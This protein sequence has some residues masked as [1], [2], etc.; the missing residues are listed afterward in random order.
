MNRQDRGQRAAVRPAA[1]LHTA[2]PA[3]RGAVTPHP[4]G[5]AR[6]G[7]SAQQIKLIAVAAMVGDHLAW[8]LLSAG[9]GAGTLLHLMGRI[10]APVM[11]FFVAE[12][13][14]HSSH[15]GRYLLR[16]LLCAVPS[17]FAYVYYF[18]QG[19]WETTSVI[20]GLFCGLAALSVW[21]LC[22]GRRGDGSPISVLPALLLTAGA[23]AVCCWAAAGGDWS[24]TAVLWILSCG[25]LHGQR[26]W[27]LAALSAV[28]LACYLLPAWEKAGGPVFYT[29]GI[30]LAVPLLALYN[31]RRS[32]RAA[33]SS[34][35]GR[36]ERWG[37]WGF[38]L[39]Y[40][41][42]LWILGILRSLLSPL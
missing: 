38:Y 8:W 29:L 24:Y 17:H 42:H 4:E 14:Y 10:T 33:V 5:A 13:C 20:W 41:L 15:L 11:C 37:K 18:R 2:Q 27:Q 12:G 23:G 9:S 30:F 32:S 36:G 26:R 1:G 39:F 3:G 25:L 40:P 6:R 19:L 35:R 34:G 7:L 28:G 16:L 31:G 22:T 21:R